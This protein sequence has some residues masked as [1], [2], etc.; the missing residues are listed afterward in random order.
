M[1][2]VLFLAA[3]AAALAACAGSESATQAKFR[4]DDA[5]CKSYGAEHGTP[6]KRLRN[7]SAVAMS[8]KQNRI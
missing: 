2:R 1:F 4:A 8:W 6:P 3:T 5:K 7:A